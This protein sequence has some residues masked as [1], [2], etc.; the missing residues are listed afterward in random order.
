MLFTN[1]LDKKNVLKILIR[2]V[3]TD[4]CMVYAQ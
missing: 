2:V 3:V 4:E 1:I